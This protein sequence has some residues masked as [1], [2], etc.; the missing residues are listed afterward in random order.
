M[1]IAA[2]TPTRPL[3]RADHLI[4]N[5]RAGE[6]GPIQDRSKRT[7]DRQR[8][9][10]A[11]VFAKVVAA[12]QGKTGRPTRTTRRSASIVLPETVSFHEGAAD[13]LKVREGAAPISV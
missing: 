13:A 7:T 12:Q 6:H 8:V 10:M 4:Q 5:S 2:Q 11:Q 3:R 9:I 1:M